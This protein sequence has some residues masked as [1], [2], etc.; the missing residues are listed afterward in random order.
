[1]LVSPRCR[2]EESLPS[3]HKS[4]AELRRDRSCSDFVDLQQ[5]SAVDLGGLLQVRFRERGYREDEE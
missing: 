2:Q 3:A 1:M 5:M 4:I